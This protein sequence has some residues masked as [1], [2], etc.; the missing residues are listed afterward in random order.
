LAIFV[1]AA[2]NG[3]KSFVFV[4]STRMLRSARKRMRFFTPAF[5]SRQMIWNAVY[6]FPVPVAITSSAR[7]CPVAMASTVRLM[8]LTW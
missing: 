2:P 1:M 4:W 6:V 7:G 8:A 3:L 5:H